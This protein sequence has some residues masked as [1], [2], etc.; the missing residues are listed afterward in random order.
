MMMP[1]LSKAIQVQIEKTDENDTERPPLEDLVL[2]NRIIEY[3]STV[4]KKGILPGLERLDERPSKE[5]VGIYLDC[6]QP[7]SQ[8][9]KEYYKCVHKRTVSDSLVNEISNLK[10]MYNFKTI[11]QILCCF[12]HRQDYLISHPEI[13]DCVEEFLNEII[14]SGTSYSVKDYKNYL[15]LDMSLEQ[16]GF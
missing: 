16:G 6:L 1:G 5:F 12:C 7:N 15:L 13:Y 11:V 2:R 10:E 9:V 8:I 3:Y 14:V 4:Y